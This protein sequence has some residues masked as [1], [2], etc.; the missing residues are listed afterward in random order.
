[1]DGASGVRTPGV[2]QIDVNCDDVLYDHGHDGDM[3]FGQDQNSPAN[4]SMTLKDYSMKQGC[5]S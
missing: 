3:H 4:P 5:L 1:M 2:K